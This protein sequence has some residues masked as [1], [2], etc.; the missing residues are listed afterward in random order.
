MYI[1]LFYGSTNEK[2]IP[3]GTVA[4]ETTI[5]LT[6]TGGLAE[7]QD[8]LYS[9]SDSTKMQ[10]LGTISSIVANTSV[11]FSNAVQQSVDPN[12]LLW[13]PTYSFDFGQPHM[14]DER[15][16]IESHVQAI[17]G[18]ESG[19]PW[20][21][22]MSAPLSE[23]E[24]HFQRLPVAKFNLLESFVED[25][26]DGAMNEVILVDYDAVAYRGRLMNTLPEW[27][28]VWHESYS[29]RLLLRVT[30]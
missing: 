1:H 30:G 28:K 11:T 10:Y 12:G 8:L 26:A 4:G 19:S 9:E 20:V 13:T 18:A 17:E 27:M 15:P 14:F 24:R 6:N 25:H 7:G 22:E 2:V 23:V 29:G 21:T 5:L 3:A 16:V